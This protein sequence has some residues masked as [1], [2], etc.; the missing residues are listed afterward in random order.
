MIAMAELLHGCLGLSCFCLPW[1][2]IADT[3]VEAIIETKASVS[4]ICV[5]VIGGGDGGDRG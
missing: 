2:A 3:P 1:M 4:S 5:M